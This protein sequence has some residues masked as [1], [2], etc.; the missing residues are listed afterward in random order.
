ME[1]NWRLDING[2]Y[3]QVVGFE[4]KEVCGGYGKAPAAGTVTKGKK[5][6][7][8]RNHK[9]KS[10]AD[11]KTAFAA[12][13]SIEMKSHNPSFL[14]VERQTWVTHR[15]PVLPLHL[16]ADVGP[17]FPEASASI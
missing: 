9:L 6:Q 14:T 17:V 12:N 11:L 16:C 2:E 7:K 13:S 10:K 15:H 4:Q 1:S 8:N 5:E 3:I